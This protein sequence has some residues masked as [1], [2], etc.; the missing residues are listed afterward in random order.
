M[1]VTGLLTQPAVLWRETVTGRDGFNQPIVT[2]TPES[3]MCYMS[4]EDQQADAAVAQSQRKV[5][6]FLS[7]DT[8]MSDVDVI[9]VGNIAFRPDGQPHRQWNP[10]MLRYEYLIVPGINAGPYVSEGS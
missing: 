2:I 8:D 3:V 6:I 10:R 7:A 5:R 1:S 9:V 4:L